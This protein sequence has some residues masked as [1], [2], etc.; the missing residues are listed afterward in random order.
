MT[1]PVLV[2][3]QVSIARLH[4]EAGWT[5]GAVTRGLIPAGA[6]VLAGQ[7]Q[8]WPIVS[9]GCAPVTDMETAMPPSAAASPLLDLPDPVTLSDAQ[10]RGANCVWCGAPLAIGAAHDLGPRPVDAHGTAAGW[11]PRCCPTCWKCHQ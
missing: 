7:T 8:P 6:V 2:D 5:C 9:C 11:F 10:Q 3:G 1:T 4:G